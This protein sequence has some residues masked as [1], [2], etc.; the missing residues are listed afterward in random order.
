MKLLVHAIALLD[1]NKINTTSVSKIIDLFLRDCNS[2]GK[3]VLGYANFGTGIG[4]TESYSS[5]ARVHQSI[6]TPSKLWYLFGDNKAARLPCEV[7]QD[8]RFFAA[9]HA[10]FRKLRNADRLTRLQWKPRRG[11]ARSERTPT[12]FS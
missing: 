1:W 3:R 5:A 10:T 6:I 4:L 9:F 2:S 8:H 11:F 12:D 7:H